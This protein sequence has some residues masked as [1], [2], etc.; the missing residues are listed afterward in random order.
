M[1]LHNFTWKVRKEHQSERDDEEEI[2]GMTPFRIFIE[3]NG[4]NG[5]WVEDVILYRCE[6]AECD[7][8]VKLGTTVFRPA[9]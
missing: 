9:S 4:W 1:L 8:S 7:C 5:R 3:L 6:E 2:A